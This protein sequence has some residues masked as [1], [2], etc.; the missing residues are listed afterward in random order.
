MLDYTWMRYVRYGDEPS[1]FHVSRR[2]LMTA[3]ADLRD[4]LHIP[5][6]YKVLFLQ[7]GGALAV[8]RCSDEPDEKWCG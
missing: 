6:N 4:L 8:F 7:G 1:F 3:E 2:S 5:D